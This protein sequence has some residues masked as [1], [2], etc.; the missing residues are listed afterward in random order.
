M[1]TSAK[2][3]A[4]PRI[5]YVSALHQP[6]VLKRAAVTPAILPS[7]ELFQSFPS[8]LCPLARDGRPVRQLLSLLLVRLD[9]RL[10][11]RPLLPGRLGALH[12]H[13]GAHRRVADAA[14]LGA[15]QRVVPRLVR[16][17]VCPRRDTRDVVL[18]DPP[19]GDPE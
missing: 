1:T 12:D 14:E 18:L 8:P 10:A 13:R 9:R 5:V 15:D 3:K 7:T 17:D 4:A 19:L 6:G 16:G 2:P 11:R